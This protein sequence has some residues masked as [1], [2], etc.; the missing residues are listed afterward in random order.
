MSQKGTVMTMMSRRWTV[1]WKRECVFSITRLSRSV[2]T[3]VAAMSFY[4]AKNGVCGYAKGRVI[5]KSEQGT[6]NDDSFTNNMAGY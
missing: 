2:P 4:V 5:R 6:S 1:N 3:F